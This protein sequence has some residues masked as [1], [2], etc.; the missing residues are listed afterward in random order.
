M[1]G[2]LTKDRIL[3]NDY[4]FVY[5]LLSFVF[6]AMIVVCIAIAGDDILK[7]DIMIMTFGLFSNTLFVTSLVN[8]SLQSDEK[9]GFITTAFAQPALRKEYLLSKY[10]LAIILTGVFS[11][12]EITA[13]IIGI[14][15]SGK[16][17]AAD[18]LLIIL[19]MI[20]IGILGALSISFNC[21]SVFIRF[22][23][24]KKGM[25]PKFIVSFPQ[26][27]VIWLW[28]MNITR[29]NYN[30]NYVPVCIVTIL[31]FAVSIIFLPVGLKWAEKKEV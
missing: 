14:I 9:C 7:R 25:I 17:I 8:Q 28:M 16:M 27:F 10:V 20:V 2:F 5:V 15:L 1:K 19:E 22:G 21:I 29:Y 12:L 18:L 31:S 11:A 13:V 23:A 26:I 24:S 4:F 6:N 3:L 30:F